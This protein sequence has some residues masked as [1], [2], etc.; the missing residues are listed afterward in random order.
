MSENFYF[1]IDNNSI[2]AI[3]LLLTRFGSR[4]DYSFIVEIYKA[5]KNGLPTGLPIGVSEKSASEVDST[6]FYNFIFNPIITNVDERIVIL[7]TQT[8]NDGINSIFWHFENKQ[9]SNWFTGKIDSDT[10]INIDP[11]TTHCF[12]IYN[13]FNEIIYDTDKVAIL[14]PNGVSNN[15]IIN[16]RQSF[17]EGYK[18]S[19]DIIGDKVL[20]KNIGKRISYINLSSDDSEWFPTN[21]NLPAYIN[22]VSYIKNIDQA[23]PYSLLG[24]CSTLDGLYITYNAGSNWSILPFSSKKEYILSSINNTIEYDDG[25]NKYIACGISINDNISSLIFYICKIDN[26]KFNDVLEYNFLDISD[27]LILDTPI[28]INLNWH[29]LENTILIGTNNGLYVSNN[30]H[31]NSQF[32]FELVPETENFKIN[33]IYSL[34]KDIKILCTNLGLFQYDIINKTIIYNNNSASHGNIN[35]CI[36]YNSKLYICTDNGIFVSNNDIV[37]FT[38]FN[39][40]EWKE[41]HPNQPFYI[42]G[43]PQSRAN[44]VEKTIDE[45]G[46]DK[47]LIIGTD[48]GVFISE[49]GYSFESLNN[50]LYP[51]VEV[52]K[53]IINESDNNLIHILSNTI[54]KKIPFVS[55]LLDQ[56]GSMYKRKNNEDDQYKL[57]A[58][59]IKEIY[60]YNPEA[61]F[62]I[63]AFSTS[64]KDSTLISSSKDRVGAV[65]LFNGFVTYSNELYDIIHNMETFEHFKTPLYE[66]LW[67]TFSGLYSG[68]SNWEFNKKNIKYDFDQSQDPLIEK[69]DNILLLFT[70]GLDTNSN[71]TLSDV[72]NGLSLNLGSKDF[73]CKLY[74]IAYGE[75]SNLDLLS[76]I[77]T[78]NSEVIYCRNNN[79]EDFNTIY[80]YIT[81]KERFRS[82]NGIYRKKF[83]F[84]QEVYIKYLKLDLSIFNKTKIKVRYRLSNNLYDLGEFNNYIEIYNSDIKIIPINKTTKFMEMDFMLS[85]DDINNSPSI[86]RLEINYITPSESNILLHSKANSSNSKLHEIITTI[87]ANTL[88][89]TYN[90]GYGYEYL[91]NGEI[92]DFF[93]IFN[94]GNISPNIKINSL[95]SD[96]ETNNI[97]IFKT[98][99]IDKKTYL[100]YRIQEKTISDNQLIYKAING[101]WNAESE[102]TVYSNNRIIPNNNYSTSS[103][104]GEIIFLEKRSKAEEI[105]ITI[106]PNQKITLGF[107][108]Q[109]FKDN[110]ILLLEN[111]SYQYMTETNSQNSRTALPIYSSQISSESSGIITYSSKVIGN[112]DNIIAGEPIDITITLLVQE[113]INNGNTISFGFADFIENPNDGSLLFSQHENGILFSSFQWTNEANNNYISINTSR[114][115]IN[116]HNLKQNTIYN[117]FVDATLN[118]T[119]DKNDRIFI[120]IKNFDTHFYRNNITRHIQSDS[121]LNSNHTSIAKVKG[122]VLTNFAVMFK[123]NL[124]KHT[125][126][127][128]QFSSTNESDRIHI[129]CPE[130][131]TSNNIL[132]NLTITDNQ[133]IIA[134]KSKAEVLLNV[135]EM[136]SGN[137]NRINTI[138]VLFNEED[139]GNKKIPIT[140]NPQYNNFYISA[141]FISSNI[142]GSAVGGYTTYSNKI[143]LNSNKRIL[144][145][146]LNAKSSLGLG[147][148]S[149]NNVFEYAK[150][151]AGLDFCS[152]CDSVKLLSNSS[153]DLQKE[154]VNYYNVAGEFVTIHGLEWNN[155]SEIGIGYKSIL[156]NNNTI[157][158]ISDIKN[159]NYSELLTSLL[160][161]NPIIFTQHPSYTNTSI[162]APFNADFR[163]IKNINNSIQLESAVEIYSEHGNSE[164]YELTNNNIINRSPVQS[165]SY[166]NNAILLGYQQALIANSNSN[167]SKP[168]L[169]GGE[170]ESSNRVLPALDETNYSVNNRGITAVIANDFSRDAILSAIKSRHTYCTTGARIGLEFNLSNYIMGDVVSVKE[171]NNSSGKTTDLNLEFFINIF[172]ISPTAT[173]N[174]IEINISNQTVETVLTSTVTKNNSSITYAPEHIVD[175]KAKKLAYYVRVI[176]SDRHMAWSSPIFIDYTI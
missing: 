98:H 162:F 14:I 147:R 107:K 10:N 85:S 165:H 143:S 17:L 104:D 124:F 49:S 66:T 26:N 40:I 7:V 160:N 34:N 68:G 41:N 63:I 3:S 149:P 88:Q 53:I 176:Q 121:N 78:L 8:I 21:M 6:R 142:I 127:F 31:L 111:L 51:D 20:L 45:N 167:T 116:F 55:I 152:I 32:R 136:D 170:L 33:N 164:S 103:L 172:P 65:N 57:A 83:R 115:G 69:S 72:V 42:F 91:E 60:T 50:N 100:N 11:N 76:E 58:D 18:S 175:G 140:L 61:R 113:L 70:D 22:D 52:K 135:I 109:N 24:I 154:I 59:L 23:D 169:Y 114:S 9:V 153:W 4:I 74:T 128:M 62:Q 73:N 95:I 150:N 159:T 30:S 93:H 29:S 82:R 134:T 37:D 25:D 106:S 144:W 148:Q 102:I 133:G 101:P 1:N 81:D 125:S 97:D 12:K 2:K 35:S 79:I 163:I 156:F 173:V 48:Q 90:Y 131:P 155:E 161:Y 89:K 112:T 146:D 139:F 75:Q 117:N 110:N 13:A 64:E 19:V 5:D 157:S 126:P 138:T 80:S 67:A 43:V 99:D 39:L 119:L 108:I 77:K 47:Y 123:N 130:T 54:N 118:G 137:F 15:L 158:N 132:V 86:N 27:N 71:K 171:L 56:S 38:L 120:T 28:S 87:N 36:I 46:N 174:L 105:K 145:G 151:Y 122:N 94:Q 166:I 44:C 96:S 16:N 92:Y 141:Y 168:G 84:D 129:S